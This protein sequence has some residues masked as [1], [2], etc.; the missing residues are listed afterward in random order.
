MRKKTSAVRVLVTLMVISFA[1]NCGTLRNLS[2]GTAKK[3]AV[4]ALVT[5]T[6]S[7]VLLMTLAGNAYDAGAFG[8]PGSAQAE[9]TWNKIAD[10]SLRLNEAL[11]AWTEAIRAN[12]DSS[13]YVSLVGQ[14]LAVIGA[15]LPASTRG[16]LVPVGIPIGF[17]YLARAVPRLSRPD[18][19]RM[20]FAGGS[21]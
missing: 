7:A 17:E 6:R 10:Q 4:Q 3:N 12:K 8:T 18:S 2:S 1:S 5:T 21:R 15:L 20:A 13:A 16:E 19:F 14:A 11:T 9:A